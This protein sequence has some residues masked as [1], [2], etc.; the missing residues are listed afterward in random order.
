MPRA[1]IF[2]SLPIR[3]FLSLERRNSAASIDYRIETTG[4]GSYDAND[5]YLRSNKNSRHKDSWQTA[6]KGEMKL[7][8]LNFEGEPLESHEFDKSEN[9]NDVNQGGGNEKE[10]GGG[11]FQK[12]L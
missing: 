9:L 2:T 7:E 6:K 10:F 3:E 8:R 12:E 4:G 11:I 1:C 5:I